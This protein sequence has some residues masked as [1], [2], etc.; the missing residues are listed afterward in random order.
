MPPCL[1]PMPSRRWC[2]R[3]RWFLSRRAGRVAGGLCQGPRAVGC[4]PEEE[5]SLLQAAAEPCGLGLMPAAAKPL[6]L[7]IGRRTVGSGRRR[8]GLGQGE[9]S[10]SWQMMP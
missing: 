4:P 8:G 6:P 5:V 10:W 3:D 2:Q 1:L 9:G 7:G